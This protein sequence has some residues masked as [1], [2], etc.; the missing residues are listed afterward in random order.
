MLNEFVSIQF[1]LGNAK[2]NGFHIH[3]VAAKRTARIFTAVINFCGLFVV[4]GEV[5]ERKRRNHLNL[6]KCQNC[7]WQEHKLCE[8]IAKFMDVDVYV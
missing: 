8:N 1:V 6:L 4:E 2:K 5:A 3:F 7:L